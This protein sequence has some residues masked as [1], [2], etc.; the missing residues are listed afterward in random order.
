MIHGNKSQGARTKALGD[1]KAGRVN[2]LVATDIAARGLD[3]VQLPLVV[4]FDLPLVA[5]DY[6]HRVGPHR[7]RRPR[8]SRGLAGLAGGSRSAARHPAPAAGAARAG[9]GGRIPGDGVVARSAAGSRPSS[10]GRPQQ[11]RRQWS[12]IGCASRDPV[13]PDAA[14]R[15]LDAREHAPRPQLAQ[16]R[17]WRPDALSS[18]PTRG[19]SAHVRSTVAPGV[20]RVGGCGRRRRGNTRRRSA[21]LARIGRLLGRRPQ[22]LSTDDARAGGRRQARRRHDAGRASRQGGPVRR[23]RR[24]GPRHQEAGRQGHDLPHRVDDQADRRRGDD[25]A[26]GAGQVDAR[27]SSRQAHPRIRRPQGVDAERRGAADQADD[28]AAVDEPYRRLRRQRRLH[29][30]EH[31]RPQRSR[32]RR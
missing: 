13:D 1:F 14:R 22:D 18:C 7:P 6:I 19:G 25:D 11:S 10:S 30:D 29:Q 12:S 5:E 32:C 16:T 27:R 20:G 26:L 15:A 3:I 2:V 4:N 24:A 28:D 23:L 17:C 31:H 21:R 9:G 8:R